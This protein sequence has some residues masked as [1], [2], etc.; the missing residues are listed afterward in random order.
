M[1]FHWKTKKHWW[2]LDI[3]VWWKSCRFGFWYD[4]WCATKQLDVYFVFWGIEIRKDYISKW[5]EE[6]TVKGGDNDDR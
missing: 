2:W 1:R 4:N 3:S 6:H 5:F